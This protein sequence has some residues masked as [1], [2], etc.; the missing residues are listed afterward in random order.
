MLRLSEF[1]ALAFV[2]C[3]ASASESECLR[4]YATFEDH[5]NDF[6]PPFEALIV[7][8][9]NVVIY[10]APSVHCAMNGVS[11]PSG[12]YVTLYRKQ[13]EWFNVMYIAHDGNDHS[14]WVQNKRLKVVGQ[15]GNNP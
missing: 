9:G 13:G 12:S 14:G 3:A 10:S 4:S 15:Y 7:G 2:C 6:R 5:E 1:L 11:I 8:P